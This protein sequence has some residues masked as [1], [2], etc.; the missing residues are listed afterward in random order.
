MKLERVTVK[1]FRSHSDTVVE[2]KE[3]INLII[4]QNGS[5]KSSLLDAILVG[6]YWPLR[7]KDIK[8]DE[9]TKV[10]ARDTY[11]DLIFEK[12]GTKYRITRR[13]LKGYSSGEIH[14]MKRLVGNEW[15]HV[16]EPSSKAISAFM[17]KLIPYN[18]FLNAIYIRQGQI[19][20]I[21]ESD[22][23]REKV[24]REVLNL[25]KF[26]T[27]YKKL[28]ELKGGSGGTEELIEKVKKYKALA[29]EA[30]LSKIGELAS[31]IFAEFTE[32][33]YS[34]VVVRAEENKVR[35]FVVWEGKERP[36]TFLS[37]GEGIAL[38]L[39]FR[40]AMSLYLAGEI[41][42]LILDEP[43]PY[44]DE[45]RRRKLITIMERYLKKIPQVIL[46]SHDEELKDAADHVIRISLEN[47]S[48][49]VEVVS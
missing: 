13:F 22:E 41:S 11:I 10:G 14:A 17:E 20:A 8:K 32:G 3:G 15:K 29:R 38:G 47:G 26:E 27:A 5:G 24:V 45:E 34:E 19:D 44:L 43:T 6:L 23:A 40:L 21:L 12:D 4:G 35:L 48:S 30:A 2:F 1:N 9:F 36:L 33:K 37:G 28:S 25:D 31:E 49:K 46:V 16:T 39:A 42:L 7:I 18:I